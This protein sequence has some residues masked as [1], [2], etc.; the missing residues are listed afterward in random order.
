MVTRLDGERLGTAQL[1]DGTQVDVTAAQ[2]ARPNGREA[3]KPPKCD[4]AA[5]WQV[6]RGAGNQPRS[7]KWVGRGGPDS[8][9]VTSPGQGNCATRCRAGPLRPERGFSGI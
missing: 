1:L 4:P 2:L 9:N 6:C 5:K 8:Y 3:T 7:G